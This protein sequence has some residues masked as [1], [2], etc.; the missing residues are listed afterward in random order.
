M[1]SVLKMGN[2]NR[3]KQFNL[4]RLL[5]GYYPLFNNIDPIEF[6]EKHNW[7]LRNR[8]DYNNL[9]EVVYNDILKEESIEI[10]KD[11]KVYTIPERVISV[12]EFGLI[13]VNQELDSNFI[14]NKYKSN[15]RK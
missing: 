5:N 8:V 11:D 15:L 9:Y 13:W 10:I 7:V 12:G 2:T 1:L 3:E 6:K 4:N 14:W